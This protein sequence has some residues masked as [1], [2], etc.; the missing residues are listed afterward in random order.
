MALLVTVP[1]GGLIA[2]NRDETK[3]TRMTDDR[4]TDLTVSSKEAAREPQVSRGAQVS[5]D[6]KACIIEVNGQEAAAVGADYIAVAGTISLKCGSRKEIG[7]QEKVELKPG[8][9]V[10]VGGMS[11]T[12]SKTGKAPRTFELPKPDET[13][14]ETPPAFEVTLQTKQDWSDIANVTFLD[15]AGKDLGARAGSTGSASAGGRVLTAVKSFILP[16]QAETATI[17][18]TG[19][20]EF[21]DVEVPFDLKATVGIP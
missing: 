19:W 9:E 18:V 2:V 11:F 20:E 1:E 3:I 17:V 16:Q 15:A 7:R 8:T 10:T 12:I 21:K 5:A 14:T 4:G 6:G 13:A